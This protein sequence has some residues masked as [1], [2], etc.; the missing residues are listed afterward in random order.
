MARRGTLLT[1]EDFRYMR[2]Q[3]ILDEDGRASAIRLL[4]DDGYVIDKPRTGE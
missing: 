1:F 4:F 2:I 3:M